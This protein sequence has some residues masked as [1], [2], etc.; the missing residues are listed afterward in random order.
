[1]S[2]AKHVILTVLLLRGPQKYKWGPWICFLVGYRTMK[3]HSTERSAY[4]FFHELYYPTRIRLCWCTC[5]HKLW[6]NGGTFIKG[7][8]LSKLKR[9]PIKGNWQYSC[10]PQSTNTE[11]GV[12]VS[13]SVL[14]CWK[15]ADIVCDPNQHPGTL[16]VVTSLHVQLRQNRQDN[17]RSTIF[18]ISIYHTSE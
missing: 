16:H 18:N 3:T 11:Y 6:G 13:C 17:F 9:T 14:T 5:Y 7:L 15:F 4:R 2:W 1:M 8:G 12:G 10:W